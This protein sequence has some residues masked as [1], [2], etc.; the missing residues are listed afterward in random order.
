MRQSVEVVVRRKKGMRPTYETQ[1]D[2]ANEGSARELLE[3][4]GYIVCDFE[5]YAPCD[6]FAFSDK[7]N[8]F[9]EYKRRNHNYG[10]YP[11]VMIP[12][13][14]VR[15]MLGI[16][17]HLKSEFL[18]LVQFNDGFYGAV[19]NHYYTATSGRTDR[20]DPKD[21]CRHAYIDIGEFHKL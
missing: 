3:H 11:S 19:V 20:Y 12:E 5:Q 14:K 1:I 15:Q 7:K 21:I 18:Y 4:R 10:T 2:R 13:K 9:V 16:C 17:D 6:F 8:F